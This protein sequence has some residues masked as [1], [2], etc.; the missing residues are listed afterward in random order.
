MT[1]YFQCQEVPIILNNYAYVLLG[2]PFE[3][4]GADD[5]ISLNH[6]L[7]ERPEHSHDLPIDMLVQFRGKWVNCEDAEAQLA[8]RIFHQSSE[9]LNLLFF[10]LENVL[11]ATYEGPI[12]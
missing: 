2:V 6:I 9:R 10:S 4:L 8:I 3:E 12:A 1:H 7:S 11:N 5:T